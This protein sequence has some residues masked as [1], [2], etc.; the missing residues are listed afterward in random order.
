MSGDDYA[1]Y[2]ADN[3]EDARRFQDFVADLLYEAGIPLVNYTSQQYQYNRGENRTGI[4]IKYDRR[5]HETGHVYIE[6][7]EKAHPDNARFV[8]SG[9]HREDN[10]WLLAIGDYQT[11]YLFSIKYLK[12]IQP[13]FKEVATPTS[14]GFIMPRA[15]AE[16]YALK[17]LAPAPVVAMEGMADHVSRENA[18]LRRRARRRNERSRL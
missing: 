6:V 13:K 15:E 1:D 5:M 10:T 3:L 9:I 4:E 17:V 2:Y 7:A 18:R 12:M 16:K 14:R 11:V 8:P